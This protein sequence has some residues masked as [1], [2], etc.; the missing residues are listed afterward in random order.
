MGETRTPKSLPGQS[1]PP[2]PASF[3]T[4]SSEA[5][6]DALQMTLADAPLSVV[7]TSIARLIEAHCEGMLCSI[8]LVEKDGLHLRY[9]AAPSLPDSY[10]AATEGIAVG[11][12]AGSCGTAVY[13]R[14]PVFVADILSDPRWTDFREFAQPVGL[15]AAW[16]SPIF[17]HDGRVLGTFG[18]YYRVARHPSQ[19]RFS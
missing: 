1:L 17:S 19:A 16:S 13:R 7:L 6:L 8:F 3:R 18:M 5:V 4:L 11:P 10:R 2:S 9:G 12:N 15:R 14:E